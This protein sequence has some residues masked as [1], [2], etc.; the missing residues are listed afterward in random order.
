MIKAAAMEYFCKQEQLF[1][2]MFRYWMGDEKK[3]NLLSIIKPAEDTQEEFIKL[4]YIEITTI[5][6]ISCINT[7]I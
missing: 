7:H 4:L 2:Q 5:T 3:N 6:N 1:S